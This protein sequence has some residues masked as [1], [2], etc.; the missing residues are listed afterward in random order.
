MKHVTEHAIGLIKEKFAGTDKSILLVG[1]NS[2]GVCLLKLLLGKEPGGAARRGI[3]NVGIWMVEE[4]SDGSFE[5]K[6]YNDKPFSV[7]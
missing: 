2:A 7:D 4:Q 5:I 3:D 1:H 6:I